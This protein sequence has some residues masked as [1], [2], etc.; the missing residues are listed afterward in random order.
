MY[1][2]VHIFVFDVLDFR[3]LLIPLLG[4]GPQDLWNRVPRI[5]I[6]IL[7]NVRQ[8]SMAISMGWLWWWGWR[9]SSIFIDCHKNFNGFHRSSMIPN[10]FPTL[11]MYSL[12][13]T[14]LAALDFS[15]L[16]FLYFGVPPY[17]SEEFGIWVFHVFQIVVLKDHSWHWLRIF[18]DSPSMPTMVLN[19][20]VFKTLEKSDFPKLSENHMFSNIFTSWDHS[21]RILTRICQ[22]RDLT[23]RKT[24]VW[25]PVPRNQQKRT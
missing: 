10:N 25:V 8:N 11:S 4:F 6:S 23:T 16:G 21:Y 24:I 18:Q 5:E 17:A 20:Y 7:T 14:P 22:N 15:I 12:H 1:I 3:I 2:C 19:N 13:E 9:F